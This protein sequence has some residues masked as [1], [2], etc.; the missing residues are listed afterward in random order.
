MTIGNGTP[1]MAADF[2][3]QFHVGFPVYTDPSRVTYGLAGLHRRF[4][5]GLE[6]FSRLKRARAVGVSQGATA[7]DPWQQGGV[8]VV[9]PDGEVLYARAD[10]AAGD[11]APIEAI[12]AALAPG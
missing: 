7:G 6:T 1:V 4:G 8:M 12:L 5:L 10:E 9:R 3:E 2:V 11:H